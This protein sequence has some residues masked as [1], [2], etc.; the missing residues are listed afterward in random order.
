MILNIKI[1]IL[2]DNF[3]FFPN[4]IAFFRFMEYYG[5]LSFHCFLV[6][7]IDKIEGSF[8]YSV[9]IFLNFLKIINKKIYFY[10]IYNNI[11]YI[12]IIKFIKLNCIS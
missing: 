11:I 2:N 7:I 9:F 4:L 8:F 12:L 10:D 5:T 6:F 1:L 3:Y